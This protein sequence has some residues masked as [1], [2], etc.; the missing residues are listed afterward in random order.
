MAHSSLA[1]TKG[2]VNARQ[3]I[4][5]HNSER[6]RKSLST[7]ATAAKSNVAAFSLVLEVFGWNLC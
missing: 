3:L 6:G 7:A 5:H 2:A 4:G 1:K